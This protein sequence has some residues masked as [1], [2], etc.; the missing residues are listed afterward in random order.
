VHHVLEDLRRQPVPQRVICVPKVNLEKKMVLIYVLNAMQVGMRI[1]LVQQ[2]AL[3]ALEDRRLQQAPLL[4][5]CVPRVNSLQRV[6][7]YVLNVPQVSRPI[8]LD[9]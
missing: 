7:I 5:I 9:Q 8:L 3:Y 4:V 6:I 2:R 1:L